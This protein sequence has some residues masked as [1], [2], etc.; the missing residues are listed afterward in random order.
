VRPWD[1][2]LTETDRQVIARA[3][4]GKRRGLGRAPAVV[5]ID[6]QYNHIGAD[7]PILEQLDEFPSGGGAAAWE[8]LRRLV[9]VRDAARQ[10]GAPVIY[11]RFCYA[12]RGARYDGFAL[13]RGNVDRY[14]DGAP[15]TRIVAELAPADDE[16]IID[17]TTASALF[18]TPLLSY[19]VRLGVDSL[20]IGGVSTSGCVRATCVDAISY[21]FNAAV[22]EDGTADRIVASH[23][24]ALLD[25][26]MKYADVITCQEALDYLRA[27]AAAR[28]RAPASARA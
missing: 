5:L 2:I 24:V 13:K 15:G 14:V 23:K 25:I 22:L 16:L 21:G 19:L 28:G 6:C 8:A 1:D 4:Y 10:A 17:K 11:T 9:P 12:A 27:V 7:K 20:I 26:W 3:G 18:G